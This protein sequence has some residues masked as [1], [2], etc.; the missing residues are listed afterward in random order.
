MKNI[1]LVALLTL[2][3]LLAWAFES[4]N[5]PELQ[6]WHTVSLENEFTAG[7]ATAKSTLQDY[8]NQEERLFGE[9]Q[10]KVYKRIEPTDE[11]IYSRY[12]EGGLQD[13]AWHKKNWNRTFE[14]VPKK[15]IGGALLMHGLTD[16]PYSL[17][18]IGEMVNGIG[19]SIRFCRL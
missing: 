9:L 19:G 5:M 12:R 8:L 17:R 13:P 11:L 14:L 15:I 2:T 10:E 1:L 3:V 16:S 7:E 18:R 6:I 4:R